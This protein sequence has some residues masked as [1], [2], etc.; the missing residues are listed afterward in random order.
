MRAVRQVIGL[1]PELFVDVNG[2][3]ERKQALAFAGTFAD[4]GV[5]WFEEP[6]SADDLDGLRLLRD[7]APADR[8]DAVRQPRRIKT[9]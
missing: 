8:T 7:R 3:Y 4:L 9:G 2:G 5:T 1:E 6:V